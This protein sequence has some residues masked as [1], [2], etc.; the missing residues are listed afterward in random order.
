MMQVNKLS[1]ACAAIAVLLL[2][3]CGGGGGG[4]P[5]LP[6]TSGGPV[7]HATATPA[8][9]STSTAAPTATPA[10]T[11]TPAPTA[12]PKGTP[13]PGATATPSGTPTPGATA[14]PSGTPTP[15]P[16]ATPVS[17]SNY[18][19]LADGDQWNFD[20]GSAGTGTLAATA[21]GGGSYSV[22]GTIPAISDVLTA[23]LSEDSS[24]HVW[25]SGDSY[26]GNPMTT[27]GATP[28]LPDAASGYNS[29]FS[30]GNIGTVQR[31]YI[32][33]GSISVPAGT[34]ASTLLYH[35]VAGSTALDT[36]EY[37][38]GIGPVRVEDDHV[39]SQLVVCVLTS[40]TL[41]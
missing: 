19:P 36:F 34:Y 12:S 33:M 29:S 5:T 20:C 39:A 25:I 26:N 38:Y 40:Y 15:V 32:G 13:T 14:T 30:G 41:H 22:T 10:N 27:F 9:K 35:D 18:F 21:I 31:S 11:P 23:T 6:S 17:S 37:A 7:S 8:P 24:G 16:T 3:A 2:V 4:T 28:Y 1:R